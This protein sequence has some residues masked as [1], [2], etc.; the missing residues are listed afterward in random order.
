MLSDAEKKGLGIALNEATLLG[1]EVDPY[2]QIAAITLS[3]LALLPE[4]PPPDDP[5]LQLLLH[6][7]RRG[8]RSSNSARRKA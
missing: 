4:G 2:R 5:R 3:V 8:F 6:D 1:A 7:L